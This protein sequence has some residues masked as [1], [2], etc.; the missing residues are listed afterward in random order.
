MKT[1]VSD[2]ELGEFM[3]SNVNF[4]NLLVKAFLNGLKSFKDKSLIA[5]LLESIKNLL[6][7]HSVMNLDHS[8]EQTT[9]YE[10]F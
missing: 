7:C 10:Q 1:T 9:V 2:N 6:D 3:P 8:N 5:S 4:T